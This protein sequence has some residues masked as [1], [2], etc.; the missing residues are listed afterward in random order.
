M[1]GAPPL[2]N[3]KKWMKM[4]I[5]GRKECGTTGVAMLWKENENESGKRVEIDAADG[6]IATGKVWSRPN[7]IKK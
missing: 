3:V 7:E 6:R 5:S 1:Y 2:G 4:E